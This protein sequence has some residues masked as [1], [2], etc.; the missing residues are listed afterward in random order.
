MTVTRRGVAIA[1]AVIAAVVL[2]WFVFIA[3]GRGA[4]GAGTG[5]I[6]NS[7]APSAFADL[8]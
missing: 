2:L 1:F 3:N 7:G 6:L 5:D 8:Y 4:G